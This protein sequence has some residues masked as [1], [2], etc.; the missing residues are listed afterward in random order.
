MA[1]AGDP[2]EV[3]W[4]DRDRVREQYRLAI[5]Y[6]LQ[7]IMGYAALQGDA[8]PLFVI[9]GD[10]QAAGFVAQSESFDVPVHVIGP[11][12]VI[13]AIDDWGFSDGLV[14]DPGFAPW[15]MDQFRD[16]FLAAFSSEAVTR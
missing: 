6:S 8:M 5:D 10:H 14:P 9:L 13:S 2:P 15:P 7:A 11:P 1:Q 4:R 12:E 16:R 3:V